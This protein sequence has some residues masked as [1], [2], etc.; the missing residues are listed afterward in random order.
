MQSIIACSAAVYLVPSRAFMVQDA[1]ACI[2][3]STRVGSKTQGTARRARM[4]QLSHTWLEIG[5]DNQLVIFDSSSCSC[6]PNGTCALDQ[7]HCL[8]AWHISEHWR[9]RPVMFVTNMPLATS[10][11]SISADL[12]GTSSTNNDQRSGVPLG[13]LFRRMRQLAAVFA[14]RQ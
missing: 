13:R 9:L 14:L 4:Y 8:L 7:R 6:L 1:P 11:A 3:G 2:L 10:T 12:S 5:P